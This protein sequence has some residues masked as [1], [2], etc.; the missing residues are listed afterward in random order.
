MFLASAQAVKPAHEI[1]PQVKTGNMMLYTASYPMTCA[2]ADVLENQAYNRIMNYF[3]SDVQCREYYPSYMD[4]YYAEHGITIKKQ[5]GD[6]EILKSG[7]VDFYTFSYYMSSCQSAGPE[8][9]KGEGNI[10]GGVPNP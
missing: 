1:D 4:R 7:T 9:Q 6:G 2:P 5:P 3:C 10:T 8:H